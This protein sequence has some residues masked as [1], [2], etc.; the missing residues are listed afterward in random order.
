[1]SLPHW[2]EALPAKQKESEETGGERGSQQDE[3]GRNREKLPSSS[4]PPP[5]PSWVCPGRE[6]KP[7]LPLR[8]AL[9]G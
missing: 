7:L 3:A 4:R 5:I 6:G 2:E 8:D 1:M 9:Q